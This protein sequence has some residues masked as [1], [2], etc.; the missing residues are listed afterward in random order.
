MDDGFE[1]TDEEFRF[2]LLRAAPDETIAR[3]VR[4]RMSYQRLLMSERSSTH[5]DT[6]GSHSVG[7]RHVL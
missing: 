3:S 2:M 6:S 7:T 4:K 1:G 5:A